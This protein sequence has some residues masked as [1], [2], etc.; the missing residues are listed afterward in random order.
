MK[1]SEDFQ[2]INNPWTKQRFKYSDIF[3]YTLKDN[4]YLAEKTQ[5]DDFIH[6]IKSSYQFK[7]DKIYKLEFI[8]LYINGNNFD[9]GFA[10]FKNSTE[11]CRLRDASNGVSLCDEGLYINKSKVNDKIKIEN[12][13]KYE[14]IIDI[15]K[16]I[17][18]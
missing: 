11:A 15:Q 16:N 17:L 13:K 9:I 5:K 1:K 4:S 3:Y 2:E 12:G 14:F 10:D 7:K 8:P 6:S 18:Y